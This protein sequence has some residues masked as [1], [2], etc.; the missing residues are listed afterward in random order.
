MKT[1]APARPGLTVGQMMKV[2]LLWA[3]AF[4]AMAPFVA[5][6]RAGGPRSPLLLAIASAF[7]MP[8]VMAALSFFLLRRG[9]WKDR[10][11]L[12]ELLV[13]VTTALGLASFFAYQFAL[14]L[15]NPLSLG[16]TWSECLGL[17]AA[18]AALFFAFAFLMNRLIRKWPRRADANDITPGLR[19]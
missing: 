19:A 14:A 6:W 2:V 17:V 18:I 1:T 9:P 16:P 3:A 8:L 12:I 7:L 10:L 11:I 15:R 4:A 13:S 5:A